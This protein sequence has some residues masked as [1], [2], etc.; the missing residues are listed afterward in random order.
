MSDCGGTKQFTLVQILS[1]WTFFHEEVDQLYIYINGCNII[2]AK[3]FNY[4][5]NLIKYIGKFI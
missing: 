2:L 1:I 3:E 4:F 5:G